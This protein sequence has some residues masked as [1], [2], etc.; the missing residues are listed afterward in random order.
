MYCTVTEKRGAIFSYLCWQNL[1][2]YCVHW[3]WTNI[4]PIWKKEKKFKENLKWFEPAPFWSACHAATNELW[5]SLIY[6][7]WAIVP[8]Q[9]PPLYTCKIFGLI[10]LLFFILFFKHFFCSSV[11]KTVDCCCKGSRFKT[12]QYFSCD[13]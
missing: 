9:K 5:V 10:L 3:I 2:I 8:A 7:E 6:Q 4:L 13:S 12:L 1:K 11:L